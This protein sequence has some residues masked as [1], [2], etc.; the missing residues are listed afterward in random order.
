MAPALTEAATQ[1]KIKLP[2]TNTAASS[3]SV[4]RRNIHKQHKDLHVESSRENVK[5]IVKPYGTVASSPVLHLNGHSPQSMDNR[6]PSL[7]AKRQ[8]VQVPLKS[9][10]LQPRNKTDLTSDKSS[11]FQNEFL[12]T[13]GPVSRP[14]LG[15]VPQIMNQPS[16]RLGDE[17]G[18]CHGQIVKNRSNTPPVS[19]VGRSAVGNSSVAPQTGQAGLHS[20]VQGR[21]DANMCRKEGE[22]G[23][24][25]PNSNNTPTPSPVGGQAGRNRSLTSTSTSGQQQPIFT[26]SPDSSGDAERID[27]DVQNARGEASKKQAQLERRIEFLLRRLRRVQARQVEKH[28]RGQLG[29]Y[30]EHQHRNLQTVARTI[31]NPSQANEN[32][33]DLKKELLSD[34][35][36]N[37]STAALVSLVQRMQASSSLQQQPPSVKPEVTTSVL[38]MSEDVRK[39][40]KVA[41]EKLKMNLNFMQSALDSD[42]TESSSGGE[43]GEEDGSESLQPSLPT[44]PLWVAKYFLFW[45]SSFQGKYQN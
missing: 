32:S 19:D 38:T 37:L 10:G 34:G 35:V 23:R 40:S 25:V 33:S 4:N 20:Q 18:K 14:V 45:K 30:V 29:S 15:K 44:T 17:E 13:I 1:A 27:E 12:K 6:Q 28:T 36:K 8:L 26:S 21:S 16:T 43:S 22:G 2:E 7:L 11:S 41:A 39:E 42:A 31:T 5:E 24:S 3:D 9:V